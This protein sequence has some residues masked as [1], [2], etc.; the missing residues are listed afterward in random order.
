MLREQLK[1]RFV[2]YFLGI[3]KTGQKGIN[4]LL[5]PRQVVMHGVSRYLYKFC[6]F[7]HLK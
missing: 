1:K 2:E 4:A 3:K 6:T 5:I 7:Q